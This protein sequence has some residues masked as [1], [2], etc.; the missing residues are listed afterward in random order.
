M[1]KTSL[2]LLSTANQL[3]VEFIPILT[4]SVLPSSNKK[5]CYIHYDIDVSG[6]A[7]TGLSFT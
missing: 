7:Q 5:A 1:K 4:V 6:F 2:P 3:L